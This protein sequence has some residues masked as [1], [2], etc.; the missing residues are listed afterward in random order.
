MPE[1]LQDDEN[2]LDHAPLSNAEKVDNREE[3][4]RGTR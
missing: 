3:G 2:V 4:Y 1:K